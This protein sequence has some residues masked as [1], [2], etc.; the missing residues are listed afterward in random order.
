MKAYFTPT[1]NVCKTNPF[2]APKGLW[3]LA[4]FSKQK[5]VLFT[6]YYYV[7][8]RSNI[9]QFI[10]E[11]PNSG[12][13]AVSW[14]TFQIKNKTYTIATTH[15]TWSPKGEETEEQRSNME[16]LLIQLKKMEPFILCG[17]FNAPR[18]KSIYK[19]LEDVYKDNIPKEITSTIDPI[20]H[21]ERELSFVVDSLFTTS[22][23]II[24]AIDIVGGLSDHKG[25]CAIL[26]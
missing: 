2:L 13:R 8:K 25:I 5:P 19:M 23:Y 24:D 16:K 18:G 4:I 1:M 20:L 3:G 10:Y 12:N 11:N 14:I 15:F 22:Q 6:E 21:R 7:G 9:P 17:D 26:K